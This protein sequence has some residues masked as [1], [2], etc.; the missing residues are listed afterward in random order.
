MDVCSTLNTNQFQQMKT[1]LLTFTV[2]FIQSIVERRLSG[3]SVRSFAYTVAP[4]VYTPPSPADVAEKCEVSDTGGR[5]ELARN[6]SVVQ[7]KGY[8]SD[9][10]LEELESPLLTI[11]DKLPLSPS[12]VTNGNGKHKDNTGY[13]SVNER[14]E[15]LSE[16]WSM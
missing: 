14:Y 8:T 15:L 9:E 6:V 3:D 13:A 7:R 16:V 11:I 2:F 12:T 5:S 1:S 10:E 4:V